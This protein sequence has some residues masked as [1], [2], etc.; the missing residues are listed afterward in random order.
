MPLKIKYKTSFSGSL[1]SR[2]FSL[3]RSGILAH[4]MR[5]R[6]KLWLA[7]FLILGTILMASLYWTLWTTTKPHDNVSWLHQ[8]Y[9]RSYGRAAPRDNP[10]SALLPKV[11]GVILV[12]CRNSDREEMASTLRNF[13]DRFNKKYHYPYVF[14]NNEE[15]DQQFT[16]HIRHVLGPTRSV[17]FGRVPVEHWSYPE[18]I[19]QERAAKARAEMASKGVIYGGSESYRF[20]CRY[21]SGFF[22]QH[23]LLQ[24]YEYY[25]R[26]EPGV[27]FTC[28]INYDV[29]RYM[30]DH[31]KAYGF[32][33][34]MQEIPETIPTLWKTVLEDYLPRHPRLSETIRY[35]GPPTPH[36]YNGCHF[37]SNFEIASL[38]FFRSSEYAK[39]FRVLDRK[40]GFFYE[41]WGDAPVHSIAVG[42][43]LK[44]SQVHYFED[45]GYR[46]HPFSHCPA[47]F[48]LRKNSHCDCDPF[49]PSETTHNKCQNLWNVNYVI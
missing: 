24:D 12:L 47:D 14:L 44:T 45:I 43:F 41:R 10:L 5:T 6:P 38:A 26:I 3:S 11:K 2:S 21:Y 22:Y 17:Q 35:F 1:S 16:K 31:G 39:F 34:T 20:M 13:E 42:L 15:F 48:V 9:S 40:G 28:D 30:K 29:F 8:Y 46:H 27:S 37:W 33:I 25:W 49:E 18:W 19:D 36:G 4:S 23:P 7:G 32:V